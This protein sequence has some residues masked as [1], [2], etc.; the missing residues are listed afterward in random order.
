[1]TDYTKL[2]ALAESATPGPWEAGDMPHDL[3]SVYGPSGCV[4]GVDS[5]CGVAGAIHT[6]RFIAAADPTTILAM[7]AEIETLRARAE[8]AER[9]IE[10]VRERIV[11]R[12]EW[13]AALRDAMRI[14]EGSE[15]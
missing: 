7:L 3:D 1:M 2:K 4:A 9:K 6:A 8:A 12:H 5:D 15:S 11:N 10:A 13:W 14:I